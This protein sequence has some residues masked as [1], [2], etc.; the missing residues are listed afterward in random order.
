MPVPETWGN[1]VRRQLTQRDWNYARAATEADLPPSAISQWINRPSQQPSV[2]NVRKLA[3]AL[4]V[5]ILEALVVA[6]Y[7][8]AEEAGT[9]TVPEVSASD[10]STL[11]LVEELRVR[12]KGHLDLLDPQ[13]VGRTSQPPQKAAD[14]SGAARYNTEL[15]QDDD[16]GYAERT[17]GR[18]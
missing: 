18:N 11:E 7:I 13:P 16:D 8:S 12:I 9:P 5:N 10:V 6:G 17:H 14:A 1:W 15:D 3:D 2:A 4:N